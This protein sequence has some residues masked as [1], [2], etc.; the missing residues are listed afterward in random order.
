[1]STKLISKK[2]LVDIVRGINSPQP[3]GFVALS[4]PELN[5]TAI[6][7][8][9]KIVDN[10]F[11]EVVKFSKVSA[12]I[13]NYEN[14]VNKKLGTDDFKAQERTWGNHESLALIE[15]KGKHYIQ[16]KVEKASRPL[17]YERRDNG[18]LR[19]V[20]TN[21]LSY[22]LRPSRERVI[23][24]VNY[25]LDNLVSFNIAGNRYKIR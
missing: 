2:D 14:S 4:K 24:L 11:N 21:I 5:K 9:N 6:Y 1:M 20:P 16:V 8:D 15:H 22:F 18:F 10:P 7:G 25:S 17:Y 3:V 23:T 12:F 19:T 13:V